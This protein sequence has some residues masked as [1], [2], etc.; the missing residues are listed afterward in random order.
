MPH[1]DFLG[2]KIR[3]VWDA[4]GRTGDQYV[5]IGGTALRDESRML[6]VG[7]REAESLGVRLSDIR[8]TP[9]S[10]FSS[11]EALAPMLLAKNSEMPSLAYERIEGPADVPSMG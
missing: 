4:L 8:H 7:G 5:L 2:D 9:W 3:N 6:G 1:L 10:A 11:L